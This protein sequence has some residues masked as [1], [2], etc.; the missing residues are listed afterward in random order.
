MVEYILNGKTVKVSPENEQAFLE[1][2]PS[3]KKKETSWWKGEEGWVPDELQGIERPK[4]KD[5]WCERCE[6]V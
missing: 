3:A 1:A 4:V 2:N 6:W 5:G